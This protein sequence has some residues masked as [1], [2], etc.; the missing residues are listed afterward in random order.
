M[1]IS[2]GH[3]REIVSQGNEVI[4]ELIKNNSDTIVI[5]FNPHGDLGFDRPGFAEH[6][7][8]KENFDVLVFK[9]LENSWYQE[10]TF[11]QLDWIKKNILQ[12]YKKRIGYGCSMG[13]YAALYFS[14]WLQLTQVIAFCPQYS[15]DG[16]V[17]PYEKRWRY[18][19]ERLPNFYRWPNNLYNTHAV[20]IYDPFAYTDKKHVLQLIN[21]FKSY[22][23]I[24]LPF[25]GHPSVSALAEVGY[26]KMVIG[27]LINDEQINWKDVRVKLRNSSYDYYA[28]NIIFRS[29]ETCKLRTKKILQLF[30]SRYDDYNFNNL[31]DRVL[32]RLIEERKFTSAYKLF[33]ICYDEESDYGDVISFEK[34]LFL[35]SR[36]PNTVKQLMGYIFK[37]YRDYYP[38]D[39]F[40]KAEQSSLVLDQFIGNKKGGTLCF[41][42]YVTL[43]ASNF[44]VIVIGAVKEAQPNKEIV[45][46]ITAEC[47]KIILKQITFNAIERD[48]FKEIDITL[49]SQYQD[50]EVVVLSPDEV[51]TSISKVELKLVSTL[52]K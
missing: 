9:T 13:A 21:H 28:V 22:D 11:S 40:L 5:T 8:L 24:S 41:G 7:L 17:C 4:G 47:G 33:I 27:S 29:I 14:E 52:I 20:I 51:L 18:E 30:R 42:P 3:K 38:G 49:A 35:L 25:S 43:P 50:I 48:F 2:N 45:I 19:A 16:D 23:V 31:I 6:F 46:R 34:H 15:I 39:N 12:K 37:G 32:H 26:L 36:V 1:N 10:L 44:K